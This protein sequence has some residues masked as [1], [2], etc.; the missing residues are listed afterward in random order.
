MRRNQIT[1]KIERFG[2]DAPNGK[3]QKIEIYSDGNNIHETLSNIN[4][5]AIDT[6]ERTSKIKRFGANDVKVTEE[7]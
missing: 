4:Q 6:I 1:L 7:P 5:L 2:E 3:Y